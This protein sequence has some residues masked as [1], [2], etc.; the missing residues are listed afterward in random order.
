MCS[1]RSA[2]RRRTARM[3]GALLACAFALPAAPA[4]A[5]TPPVRAADTTLF[6][7]F[8]RD[9]GVLVSFGEFAQ[10]ADRVVLSVPVGGPDDNPTLHVLSVAQQDIDWERTTAYAR[11]VRAKRYADTRGEADFSALSHEVADMLNRIAFVG[12]AAVRLSLAESAR[13]RL[14]EWPQQHYGYRADD[15]AQM[16]V[17]LDQVVSELRIA[18]GRSSFD[19][20]FVARAPAGAPPVRVLPA[21]TAGERI[22]SALNAARRAEASQRIPL[23]RAVLEALAPIADGSNGDAPEEPWRALAR[24]RAFSELR[25]ELE[26]ERRYAEL[27]ATTLEK[28]DRHAQRADVRGLQLLVQSVLEADRAF[29]GGRP[30]EV[31]ALLATLDSRI[32]Q[33]RRLR[34]ARDAWSARTAVIARYWRDVRVALDR[35]IGVRRWLEDVR[36][37]AGPAPRS[38]R[39]LADLAAMAGRELAEVAPPPEVASSHASLRSAAGLAARAGSVRLEAIRTGSMDTAWQASSAAAGSLLLLDGA[40]EELRRLTKAPRP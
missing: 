36:E 11:A 15:V 5:Q 2:A 22:E 23:L 6:R 14:L 3:V 35:L 17:W 28:A 24:A 25:A 19:L 8:L 10:V 34:L 30:A 20:A 7:V 33:A 12:D 18:A 26:I 16:G 27:T 40:I 21:P 32:D 9:G 4:A 38:T 13:R 37:L 1:G 39:R 29:A 31:S